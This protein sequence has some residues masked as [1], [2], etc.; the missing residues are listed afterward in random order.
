[1]GKRSCTCRYNRNVLLQWINALFHSAD[2]IEVII[3]TRF[4][5]RE[6]L[7]TSI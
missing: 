3:N 2:D 7:E 5:K 1:M 4:L 6:Q